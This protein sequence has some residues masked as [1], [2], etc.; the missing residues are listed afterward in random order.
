M[1]G[2]ERRCRYTTHMSEQ[3]IL[4]STK[5]IAKPNTTHSPVSRV[6]RKACWVSP[7]FSVYLAV[8]WVQCI[9]ESRCLIFNPVQPNLRNLF[10]RARDTTL[11]KHSTPTGCSPFNSALSIDISRLW[12]EEGFGS[13]DTSL[14]QRSN[15]SI[16]NRTPK[17]PHP[18]G[19]LC[20]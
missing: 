10:R 18:V 5:Q 11:D 17:P 6:R 3:Y 9:L 1:S 4:I 8:H 19:V 16:E 14:L 13:K 2:T 7:C 15:M 20:L 12:R